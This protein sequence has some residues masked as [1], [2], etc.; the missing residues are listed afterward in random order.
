MRFVDWFMASFLYC[1][2][3]S[4]RTSN[5]CESNSCRSFTLLKALA[6]SIGNLIAIA[7]KS[8]KTTIGRAITLERKPSKKKQRTDTKKDAKRIKSDNFTRSNREKYNIAIAILEKLQFLNGNKNYYDFYGSNNIF[9][10][11][12]CIWCALVSTT[13]HSFIYN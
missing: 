5:Y 3:Y 6:K 13:I 12:I 9:A 2:L 7:F 8:E 4:Y 10:D 1:F 11:C